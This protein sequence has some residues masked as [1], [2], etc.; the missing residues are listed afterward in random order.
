MSDSD[1][2][3]RPPQVSLA[4]W[5]MIIG[6]VFGVIGAFDQ[7]GKLRSVE[8]RERLTELVESATMKELGVSVEGMQTLTHI[9][10]LLT[11]GI[12]AAATIL[13]VY[14]LQR[15][16]GARIAITIL[17]VPLFLAA[18]LGGGFWA[19]V[20]CMAALF[21]WTTPA[22]AWFAGRPVA[23]AGNNHSRAHRLESRWDDD[24]AQPGSSPQPGAPAEPPAD[25]APSSSP[26]PASEQAQPSHAR[27][28]P[29]VGWGQPQV[30]AAPPT[31]PGQHLHPFPVAPIPPVR[32][33]ATVAVAALLA[34][35]GSVVT[36]FGFASMLLLL[37]LDRA[38]FDALL[39]EVL[40]SVPQ[41]RRDLGASQ[42]QF[43]N[44]M[45]T[46]MAV[47]GIAAVLV[48][49]FT[50]V[51]AVLTLR[52]KSWAWISLIVLASG[53]VFAGLLAFPLG[54]LLSVAAAATAIMLV[55]P[56][57]R[58]WF[59]AQRFQRNYPPT[60]PPAAQPPEHDHPHL[61]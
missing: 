59:A 56:R 27:P 8:T 53:T 58:A 43:V 51:V 26:P 33:P 38:G 35:V 11:G 46:A 21:L 4:A 32:R 19:A 60:Q 44:L 41:L 5:S 47:M 3:V 14:V 55:T 50:I 12:A 6:G 10:L 18:P 48:A 16:H 34:I 52:G 22:R 49:L 31:A 25:S 40:E 36:I 17:A 54:L 20:I 24:S 45:A 28:Q 30:S 13:G 7:M 61:W 29:M 23:L 15:H 1:A 39:I 2:P 37:A 57:V 42:E 9:A